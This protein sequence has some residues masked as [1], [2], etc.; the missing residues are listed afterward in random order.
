MTNTCFK[1]HFYQPSAFFFA[2]AACMRWSWSRI[3]IRCS[4]DREFTIWA[5]WSSETSTDGRC[6]M[7]LPLSSTLCTRL[8]RPSPH[9]LADINIL[10][11]WLSRI[12]LFSL[13]S[14]FKQVHNCR[15][16]RGRRHPVH[17]V[18]KPA[19]DAVGCSDVL[20]QGLLLLQ[21]HLEKIKKTYKNRIRPSHTHGQLRF[22]CI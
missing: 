17:I 22:L 15:E 18:N 16:E 11:V 19:A 7:S 12:M 10:R 13:E 21:Y 3:T 14:S 8:S 4:A 5:S 2:S 1:F 9:C 6:V 20:V